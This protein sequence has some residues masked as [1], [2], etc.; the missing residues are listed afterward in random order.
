MPQVILTVVIYSTTSHRNKPLSS[1]DVCCAI[2]CPEVLCFKTDKVNRRRKE[3]CCTH[4]RGKELSE[5]WTCNKQDCPHMSTTYKQ[6]LVFTTRTETSYCLIKSVF[7]ERSSSH[8]LR[9]PYCVP[10]TDSAKF[11]ITR[12]AKMST[13]RTCSH[14]RSSQTPN[15]HHWNGIEFRRVEWCCR[16]VIV[17]LS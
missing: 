5:P 9:T 10:S 3:T 15:L 12:Q 8:S 13:H 11:V 4:T 2:W 1:V 6:A 17:M 16:V 7:H 14:S